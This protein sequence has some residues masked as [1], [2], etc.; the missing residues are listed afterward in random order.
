[1]FNKR[2]G[3]KFA[4]LHVFVE[5]PA[6]DD[7]KINGEGERQLKNGHALMPPNLKQKSLDSKVGSFSV[8]SFS[9]KSLDL[10]RQLISKF[11][12]QV[13]ITENQF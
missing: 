4:L 9:D 8:G 5:N 7:F 2:T 6:S 13:R 1:M 10:G 12:R 11:I 3:C